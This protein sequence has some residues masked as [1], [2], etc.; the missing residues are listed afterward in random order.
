LKSYRYLVGTLSGFAALCLAGLASGVADAATGSLHGTY[1]KLKS[2]APNQHPDVN[3]GIIDGAVIPGLVKSTLG[4]NGLP[5]ASL[6]GQSSHPS[7]G[8]ADLNGNDEILWWT[9]H[10]PSVLFEKTQIDSV[11]LSFLSGFY[12]D[13]EDSNADYMRA[14]HW[15]GEFDLDAAS[16]IPMFLSADDDAWVFI[17]G[18]LAVDNGGIKPM[19]YSTTS[20]VPLTA[21]THRIDLFFADRFV[22]ESGIHFDARGLDF[23]PGDCA[24]VP[25]P[26]TLAVLGFGGVPMLLARRRKVSQA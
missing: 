9:A 21:G 7:P 12:P 24:P 17:D 14:V 25:E 19:G 4:P 1:Y 18:T 26:C 3:G 16:T 15:C 6:L 5:V 11:P 13:G 10:G 23:R 8:F 2:S 22:V 20:L